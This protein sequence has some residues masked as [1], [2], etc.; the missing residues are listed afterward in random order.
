MSNAQKVADYLAERPEI[1]KVIHPSQQSGVKRQR[2]KISR[3][4]LW[5]VG[6]FRA[7]GR[8]QAGRRS[9][10]ALELLYHVANI[11]VVESLNVLLRKMA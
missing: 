8:L 10:D 7:E 4:Q 11:V 9:I 2:P 5:R 1:T 6:R 3:R